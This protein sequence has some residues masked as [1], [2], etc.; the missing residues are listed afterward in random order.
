MRHAIVPAIVQ[1]IRFL[2]NCETIQLKTDY[3]RGANGTKLRRSI[4][5]SKS[6]KQPLIVFTANG[7]FNR[8]FLLFFSCSDFEFSFCSD[9]VISMKQRVVSCC[10]LIT[11]KTA[12]G[13][14]AFQRTCVYSREDPSIYV[15]YE[16]EDQ[17]PISRSRVRSLMLQKKA[18]PY[19]YYTARID[20]TADFPDV[21]DAPKS[22][23]DTEV[24]P[25]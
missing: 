5:K 23:K 20:A 7:F 11:L 13:T 24:N 14:D 2:V 18:H 9:F 6:S 10:Y 21:D 3:I 22:N 16:R 4:R 15:I 25:D 19:N 17:I 12:L 1:A 8:D